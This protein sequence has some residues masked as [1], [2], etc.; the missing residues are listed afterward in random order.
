M[1]Q[2]RFDDL[3]SQQLA[4]NQKTWETLQGHGIDEQTQLR[5]DFSYNAATHEA[6]KQ[7]HA[8]LAEETGYDVRMD[9]D[10]SLWRKRWRVEGSTQETTVSQQI[11]DEWVTWMVV[12][13]KENGACD[14]D[15]WGTSL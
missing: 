15:G 11:L 14:F 9:S 10:G 8:F 1:D 7:L 6:A 12:A 13:G 2:S 5:L 3:L 4:M